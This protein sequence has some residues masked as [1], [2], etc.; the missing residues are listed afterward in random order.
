M[1]KEIEKLVVKAFFKKSVQP[2]ILFELF[3]QK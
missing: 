1:E 3:S 2:R